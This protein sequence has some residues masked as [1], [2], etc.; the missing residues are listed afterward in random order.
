VF[1]RYGVRLVGVTYVALGLLGFLPIDAINPLHAEGVGAHY[2]FNLVA[3]NWLHDVIHLGIGV[4]GLWASGTLERCRLW[5]VTVGMVLLLV[6]A[7]GMVQAALAGYPADQL[8]LGLVPLN[9]PGH[10]LHLATGG[11]AVYLGVARITP[12]P[13]SD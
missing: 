1:I 10:M 4:S 7:A 5:G 12:S 8:L 2:L 9:S 6:F 13:A 11:L 3:I